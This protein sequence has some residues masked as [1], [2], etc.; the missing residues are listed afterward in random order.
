MVK[1]AFIVMYELRS[2]HKTLANLYDNI[3]NYYDADIIIVCQ[4]TF[5]NDQDNL[6]LFDKKVIFC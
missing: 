2:I 4:E 1:F 5:E 6:N 3:I